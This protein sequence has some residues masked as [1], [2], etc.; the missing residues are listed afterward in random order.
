MRSGRDKQF[1]LVFRLSVALV[2]FSVARL[3]V[4]I[5]GCISCFIAHLVSGATCYTQG[6]LSP[7]PVFLLLCGDGLSPSV[8]SVRDEFRVGASC[9]RR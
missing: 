7:I 1:S 3:L 8:S 5:G 6:G 4:N 2:V 9:R